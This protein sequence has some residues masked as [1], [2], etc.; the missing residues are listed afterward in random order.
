MSALVHNLY[1][2]ETIGQWQHEKTMM[3][4][5]GIWGRQPVLKYL[6]ERE[7]GYRCRLGCWSWISVSSDE[8]M[9]WLG[10]AGDRNRS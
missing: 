3:H 6:G 4:S 9:R 7:G 5:S 10:W 1:N 8:C 2:D